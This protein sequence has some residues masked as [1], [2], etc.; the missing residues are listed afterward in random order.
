MFRSSDLICLGMCAFA[1]R[2]LHDAAAPA[3]ASHISIF[4]T[5]LRSFGC[6][7]VVTKRHLFTHSYTLYCAHG[8][9]HRKRNTSHID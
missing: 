4:I 8:L 6:L 3:R 7:S 1:M 5:V 2:C 9:Q